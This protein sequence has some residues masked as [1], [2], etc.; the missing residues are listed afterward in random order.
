MHGQTALSGDN[1][2]QARL[3]FS[4]FN[5]GALLKMAHVP[6]LSGESALAGTVTLDGPLARPAE[7]RGEARLKE[8]AVTLAGVHLQSEGGVHATITDGRVNLDPL[9]VTGEETDLHAQGSLTLKGKQQLDLAASGA[10]NLKIAETLDP[11]LTASG[12][13]TFQVEAHGP[14]DNPGLRGRIDFQNGSLA[15]EDLPN[16]L[17]QLH[18]TLEF[19]QN[20]LEVK[21]LT[22]MTGGGLLSLG[23]SLAY[24]HGIYADLTATGN[25]IRIRYPQGVSSL[26]DATLHLQGSQNN[27]LLSGN[28]L[29]TRFTMQ[30][31]PGHRRA[32]HAGH[33]CAGHRAIRRTIQPCPA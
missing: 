23:G 7:M 26:A 30:S 32:G 28:V 33:R 21:S 11:D 3:E 27:L 31:R 20:R 10:I 25:G 9:H 18:G 1:A 29:I 8:L 15:L 22:A 14:L 2:T 16:G 24:Q 13:T 19:N 6:G 4:R 5:I 17:S 12:T